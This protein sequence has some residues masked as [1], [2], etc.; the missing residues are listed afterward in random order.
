MI[1]DSTTHNWQCFLWLWVL[2]LKLRYPPQI[3]STFPQYSNRVAAH[4][5][6]MFSGTSWTNRVWNLQ[7]DLW[8]K[9]FWEL[10]IQVL[11]KDPAEW[12]IIKE[13]VF[14]RLWYQGI[15]ATFFQHIGQCP[16]AKQVYS[17]METIFT[18]QQAWWFANSS[19][20]NCGSNP[21]TW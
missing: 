4:C 14:V 10:S 3:H 19:D 9:A 5:P 8:K 6:S 21:M 7:S 11:A 20:A 12:Q 16:D 17:Y 15:M 18:Q 2:F 1:G 13:Y